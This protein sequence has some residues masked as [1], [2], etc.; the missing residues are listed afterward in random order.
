I[1]YGTVT[2]PGKYPWMVSIHERVKDVMKQACGGAILNENWIVT[3]AHCFDQPI[4]LKDYE[5]YVGIVSWLHK[6]APTVQK[7]QLSKIII[8]D[9]YVKDGFANDIALI[10]TATPIDIK[11]SKYGVNG[12]CFPSGATDPS[13]EATVIG[14]GMIRGGGPISA[15]LRQVTLPLVPWQKCKQIYGHPDSEFEYIQVVPSMLCAGGNGKDACQFDS[16]GPLFQ[17]DKKGVATLIGTVANGADCAYA[18]YPGMY[19]KVSAFRSWM[20]KVMT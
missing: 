9:K 16:G 2:T 13:G 12:I 18:H 19:M 3:A 8:H 15:E 11:G 10:K 7:F 6:N 14:W 5:V 20:D 4:I 17:Y 1:V